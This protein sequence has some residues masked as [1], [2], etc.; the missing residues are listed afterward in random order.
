[1]E[2]QCT[3]CHDCKSEVP[4]V[5]IWGPKREALNPSRLVPTPTEAKIGSED[6]LLLSWLYAGQ[7][8]E[9]G[10]I[11]IFH[12]QQLFILGRA[13]LPIYD[14]SITC[15]SVRHALLS[16]I[17]LS[18]NQPQFKA[19]S[20]WH[21]TQALR[22]LRK[23]SED[24]LE[25]GD[26]FASALFS[27]SLPQKPFSSPD[28]FDIHL[29]GFVAIMRCLS[30]TSGNNVASLTPYWPMARDFLIGFH[31]WSLSDEQFFKG[32][33]LSREVMGTH[34]F[35][36]RRVLAGEPWKGICQEL[37]LCIE[38][39]SRAL[40]IR[41]IGVPSASVANAVNDIKSHLESLVEDPFIKAVL[42][43]EIETQLSDSLNLRF[44]F[45]IC[46]LLISYFD[47][48]IKRDLIELYSAL[49]KYG[50]TFGLSSSCVITRQALGLILFGLACVDGNILIDRG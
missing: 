4:C 13:L 50:A 14:L 9:N 8:Q 19:L 33:S 6:L 12:Q 41:Q 43:T 47:A 40:R 31:R 15:L 37:D 39:A 3:N 10:R 42:E 46:N 29:E 27:F 2:S 49:R 44:R 21:R 30:N 36:Q 48:M 20:E 23:K 18:L 28:G 38:L 34:F 7:P 24:T 45:R 25:I 32:H 26:L 16:F 22:A 11:P 5:K 1:M 17:S 35:K